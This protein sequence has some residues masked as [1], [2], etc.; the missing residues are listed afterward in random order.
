MMYPAESAR[1][2]FHGTQPKRSRRIWEESK[3]GD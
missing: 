2:A 3:S 1:A